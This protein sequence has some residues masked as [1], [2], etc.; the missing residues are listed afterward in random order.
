MAKVRLSDPTIHKYK[1]IAGKVREIPDALSEGLSLTIHPSGVKSPTGQPLI[2]TGRRR[3]QYKL[4]LPR[5]AG[6]AMPFA[7][8]RK[9]QVYRLHQ[10]HGR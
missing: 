10:L 6:Q 2:L 7:T 1:P 9:R 5:Q 8:T 4:L 3:G